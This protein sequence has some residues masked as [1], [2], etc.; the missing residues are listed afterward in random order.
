MS[1]YCLI[2]IVSFL[3]SN[4][5]AQ[6]KQNFIQR[7]IRNDVSLPS[8]SQNETIHIT[9][10]LKIIKLTDNSFIHTSQGNNGFIYMDSNEAVLVSTPMSDEITKDLI[11]WIRT[12]MKVK[13]AAYVIDMWHPDAMEGLDVVHEYGIKSYAHNLT[14]KIAKEKKYPVPQNGFADSLIL[15]IGNKQ[16]ICDYLGPGHTIDG[17][18]VW[19]PDE[20]IL[21][22]SN[23]VRCLNMGYGNIADADIENWSNSIKK[24]KAKYG[25]A[26][27]V[28]PGHGKY[29][30]VELFDYTIDLY[31]ENKWGKILKAHRIQLAKVFEDHD[32]IFEVAEND[33]VIN[34]EKHLK[35]STV[36]VDKDEQYIVIESDLV[37][38]NINERTLKSE[39]GRLRIYNKTNYAKEPVVDGYYKKLYLKLR[40]D[41]VRM[42]LVIKELLR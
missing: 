25:N 33:T 18:V 11:D 2:L 39:F 26:K 22:G 4:L 27:I 13:I 42:V 41:E 14:I 36:F 17:I 9:E 15:N 28:V 3:V 6:H 29:G 7:K 34:G 5:F 32:R 1:K 12:V 38:H 30:G 20:K 24:V 21:F 8:N 10:Q 19:I 40:D 35:N 37:I 23:S 16:I 31:K